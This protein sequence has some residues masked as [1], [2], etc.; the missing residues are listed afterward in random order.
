MQTIRTIRVALAAAALLGAAGLQAQ[1]AS[2]GAQG[3]QGSGA[4]PSSAPSTAASSPA[5]A[6]LEQG[7]YLA[8]AGNCLSCHTRPGAA[9]FSGGVAFKTQLGTLYSSNITPDQATGIGGWTLED[10]RRAMHEGTAPGNRHLFPA[11]PYTSFTKVS[12]ADVAAIY[13]YLRT[14]QP[15]HYSP[16]ANSLLL[17]QRW[18]MLFWNALFFDAG[19][20]QPDAKQ[21]AEWNRGAYL[22]QGLGH[23]DACHTPRNAFLAEKTN[24]AFSGGTLNESVPGGQVRAWSAVNLTSSKGGLGSWSVNDLTRYLKSGFSPRAGTFGPMNEVIVNSLKNLTDADV[25]AMAVYLKSLPPV[26]SPEPTIA[27]A[28]I[29]AGA[30]LYSDHCQECHMASGRGGLFS[31]PPLAGSAVVQAQS[32]A[33]LINVILYGP[34]QPKDIRF[35]GWETMKPYKNVLS[36]AEVAA[37]SNYV[38]GS[39]KNH[40][41]EVTPAEVARQR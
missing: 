30:K 21:S 7:K 3:A 15:V 35:G 20:F 28:S 34:D 22:V 41:G 38:R 6:L 9:A 25:H 36:D 26:D 13:A 32:P 24:A 11:F 10:F 31:A 37:V 2:P 40:G 39:W 29:K 8:D 12:D 4:G 18:G 27:D 23:C 19:R 33:S 16:P 5:D 17:R 1:T 14:L